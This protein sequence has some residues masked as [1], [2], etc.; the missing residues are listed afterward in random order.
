[1][2]DEIKVTVCKYPDRENLVLRYVDP[3]TGKQKTKS[4]GTSDEATAI[5]KAAVWQDELTTGRYQAPSRLTWAEFRK[6]C[7]AEKLSAMPE[8]SQVAYRVALDHLQRLIDPDRL[9]KL[10][11][12]VLSRFQAEARKEGMK[13]TT[14]A[15][16]LRHIKA[17]LRW[18]ERQGLMVKAPAI[19]MPKLPKGQSLAK[20]RAVTAEE[21]DRLLLAVPKV[22][23]KDAPAWERLLRG[24]WLSGLRL[25]EA[26]ALDWNDGPFVLDTTRKHPAFRIEAEGQKSRRNE[27]AVTV[28]EF[29]EWILA[30]TPEAERVGRVF[31]LANPTT[32]EP[33]AVLTIGP[34]VSAI[35]RKAGVVVGT[36]EK[37]VEENGKRVKRP[38]KLF[39]GAH[40]LRRAFCG[41][42]AMKVKTPV[43]QR[44]ARHAHISTTMG[45]YVNLTAD[46]IGA[47]LW[48]DHRAASREAQGNIS[49]NIAPETVENAKR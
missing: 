34:M 3:V 27:L 22:R 21:F 37:W 17:C 9:A 39:A 2:G 33:L 19:E 29:V 1:M 43:L 11:A 35:G 48:A 20:H 16:H 40:D 32:G 44:L 15:R 24:L 36:A 45:Y 18:G 23:P 12:Q 31:K 28:P 5:G 49:G 4:A 46:D 26:V 30:E 13:A 41:R 14:L 8:S 47:E 42:W 7:E 25:S 38:V 6:R 10:T